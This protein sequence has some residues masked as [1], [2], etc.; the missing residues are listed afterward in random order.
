MCTF[1]KNLKHTIMIR[2]GVFLYSNF[3]Q[4]DAFITYQGAE[5]N[6]ITYVGIQMLVQYTIDCAE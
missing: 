1:A 5:N 2:K 6:F 3:P 4:Q